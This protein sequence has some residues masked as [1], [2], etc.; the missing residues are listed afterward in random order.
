MTH[1][2]LKS[3]SDEW[4]LYARVGSNHPVVSGYNLLSTPS[5]SQP[6][7]PPPPVDVWLRALPCWLLYFEIF[8]FAK[9]DS[10]SSP[11]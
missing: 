9:M 5:P 11:H 3:H 10:K 2:K 7:P 1:H 4:N 6:P 8:P